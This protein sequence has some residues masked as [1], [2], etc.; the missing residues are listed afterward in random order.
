M[1]SGGD[2]L[3][4]FA[5]VLAAP[6]AI[7][8]IATHLI[9]GR[10][11]CC[12]WLARITVVLI[13]LS[14]PLVFA[15]TPGAR[16][17]CFAEDAAQLHTLCV[18]AAS[19]LFLV[20][21]CAHLEHGARAFY[22]HA[23][24]LDAGGVG[25]VVEAFAV[26]ACLSLMALAPAASTLT[27][28]LRPIFDVEGGLDPFWPA[29]AVLALLLIPGTFLE[30]VCLSR[31]LHERSRRGLGGGGAADRLVAGA[32]SLGH[33]L[34]LVL[35]F[36][37]LSAHRCP[38]VHTAGG[39]RLVMPCRSAGSSL[40]LPLLLLPLHFYSGVCARNALPAAHAAGGT[41][42]QPQACPR[43]WSQLSAPAT[44]RVPISARLNLLGAGTAGQVLQ[45]A[46][47]WLPMWLVLCAALG[48]CTW[49]ARALAGRVDA[50]VRRELPLWSTAL[51]PPPSY[52]LTIQQ[53][54]SVRGGPAPSP[55]APAAAAAEAAPGRRPSPP[56]VELQPTGSLAPPP[57]A[58]RTAAA[59]ATVTLAPAPLGQPGSATQGAVAS[60]GGGS[61]SSCAAHAATTPHVEPAAAPPPAWRPGCSRST[62]A[63]QPDPAAAPPRSPHASGGAESV[64][65]PSPPPERRLAAA[66]AEPYPRRRGG[67]VRLLLPSEDGAD[68]G[69]GGD[70]W[71][72]AMAAPAAAASDSEG[73]F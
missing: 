24:A 30:L 10:V 2:G 59:I 42:D 28:L 64:P 22:T 34:A 43:S 56:A 17:F 36:N 1:S 73:R 11:L 54:G 29:V 33:G 14:V 51:P 70:P 61:S 45:E 12:A 41:Q 3:L 20:F 19:V 21:W 35:L 62:R 31:Y 16:W 23:R 40:G 68:A 55:H 58:P 6:A 25:L 8:G 57:P 49:R 7:I 69:G 50:G 67:F 26:G 60:S 44:M 47:G 18:L 13:E 37:W 38:P 52:E 4:L 46:S 39:A 9:T 71:L 15:A 53:S 72:D 27:G 63:G 32:C 5:L 65:A 66:D 48:A